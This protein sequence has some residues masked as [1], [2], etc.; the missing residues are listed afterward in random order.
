MGFKTPPGLPGA[1]TRSR[2]RGLYGIA[3]Q[4]GGSRHGDVLTI[5]QYTD[6][7]VYLT[8]PEVITRSWKLDVKASLNNLI[9]PCTPETEIERL[10]GRTV[11]HYLPGKNP[12]IGEMTKLYNIPQE[13]V[14]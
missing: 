3:D 1:C 8:E 5:T 10:N 4:R 14:L 7:P 13:A 9:L 6:D 2:N 11:P 12:F